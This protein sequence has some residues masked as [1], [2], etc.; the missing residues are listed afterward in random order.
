M[1]KG[2]FPILET[3]LWAGKTLWGYQD[4]NLGPLPYRRAE[5]LVAYSRMRTILNEELGVEPAAEVRS[6]RQD[7]LRGEH[8][9]RPP[10]HRARCSPEP[11]GETAG[12]SGRE[13]L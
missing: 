12:R 7:I 8:F 1:I 5:A 6:L 13:W 10:L 2:R 9:T 3:G 4:L 11:A